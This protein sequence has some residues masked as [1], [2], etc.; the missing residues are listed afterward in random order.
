MRVKAQCPE[1]DCPFTTKLR[2]PGR[3]REQLDVATQGGKRREKG[4][5]RYHPEARRLHS[6]A[7]LPW[8]LFPYAVQCHSIWSARRPPHP[9]D[10][11][12]SA[13]QAE[14]GT[15][16]TGVRLTLRNAKNRKDSCQAS[17]G[18]HR[19]GAR[20]RYGTL[21]LHWKNPARLDA[22]EFRVRGCMLRS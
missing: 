3:P 18:A 7:Y 17:S 12:S 10:V 9:T 22:K 2:T 14:M 15:R 11:P 21:F 20:Y 4:R 16:S 6:K 5:V 13:P 1:K 8:P 19:A